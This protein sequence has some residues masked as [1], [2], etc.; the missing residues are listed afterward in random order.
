MVGFN[1]LFV[2][3]LHLSDKVVTYDIFWLVES[4]IVMLERQLQASE[5]AR[6]Q[7]LRL[8]NVEAAALRNSRVTNFDSIS[9]KRILPSPLHHKFISHIS[10]KYIHPRYASLH[11]SSW[12]QLRG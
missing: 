4:R 7:L 11:S 8:M 6:K 2:M 5:E 3:C 10:T 9:S 12:V 1:S